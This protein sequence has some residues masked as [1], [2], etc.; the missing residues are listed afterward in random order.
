MGRLVLGV[1]TETG[2]EDFDDNKNL[3]TDMMLK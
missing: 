1:V 3:I 2:I